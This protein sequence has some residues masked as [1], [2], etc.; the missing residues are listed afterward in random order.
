MPKRK[1]ESGGKKK[2]E[3]SYLELLKELN[4]KIHEKFNT[5]SEFLESDTFTNLGFTDEEKSKVGAYLS[6]PKEGNSKAVKSIPFLKLMM[7]EMM[8]VDVH[9]KVVVTRKQVIWIEE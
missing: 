7:K 9:H 2:R 4:A 3:V 6:I 5:V 8:D 1:E